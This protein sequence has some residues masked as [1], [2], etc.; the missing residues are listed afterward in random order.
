MFKN[1]RDLFIR[2]LTVLFLSADA[3]FLPS[4]DH[5]TNKTQ[6]LCPLKEKK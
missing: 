6:F 2:L 1:I 4:G 5:A 3:N